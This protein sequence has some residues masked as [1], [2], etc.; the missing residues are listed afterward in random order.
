MIV[1]K[2]RRK[3]F[4]IFKIIKKMKKKNLQQEEY[5][6][7]LGPKIKKNLKVLINKKLVN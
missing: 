2:N 1:L 7:V 3:I 5:L 6:K 4:K